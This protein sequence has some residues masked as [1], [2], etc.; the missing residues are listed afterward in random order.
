M[1]LNEFR[2]GV[3]LIKLYKE[4]LLD[5]GLSAFYLC[6]NALHLMRLLRRSGK[7]IEWFL[8]NFQ[9]TP[10]K[11]AKGKEKELE[12]SRKFEEKI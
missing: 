11:K 12:K 3:S 9:P 4:Y 1:W 2:P 7:F 10:C 8:K 6:D 5:P